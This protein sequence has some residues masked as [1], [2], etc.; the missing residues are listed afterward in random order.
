MRL[1]FDIG[2]TFARCAGVIDGKIVRKEKVSTPKN[3][4]EGMAVCFDMAKR[5]LDGE[6]ADAVVAGIAGSLDREKKKIHVCPNLS[7]W[8]GHEIV[9]ALQKAIDS[10]VIARN[11]AELAGLGEAIFG[12]GKEKSIVAYITVGTGVGGARIVHGRI[13]ESI[14]GFEPGHQ[15]LFSDSEERYLED[16]VSGSSIEKEMGRDVSEMSNVHFWEEKSKVFAAGIVNV[17]LLWSPD[18][19]VLGGSVGR[20]MSLAV[21]EECMKKHLYIFEDVPLV[22]YAEL[23]D[24]SGLWGGIALGD[25]VG[26]IK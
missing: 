26:E 6:K 22:K 4:E 10:P 13:D 16:I 11:D 7:L 19:V 5:V 8:N 1:V 24:D 9:G 20:R 17:A 2:G 25:F 3:F 18:I 23:G 15:I 14:F 12:A 21:V